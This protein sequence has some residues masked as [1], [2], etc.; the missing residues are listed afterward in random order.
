LPEAAN[1]RGMALPIAPPV[2]PILNAPR[3]DNALTLHQGV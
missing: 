3:R 2:W 1:S